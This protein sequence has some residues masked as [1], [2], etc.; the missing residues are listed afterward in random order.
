MTA[1]ADAVKDSFNALS[2]PE[3]RDVAEHAVQSLPSASGP[4]V[5]VLWLI[6][7]S[8]FALLLVGGATAVVYMTVNAKDPKDLLPLVTAA[9][10]VLAGLLAPSPARQSIR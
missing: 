6:I 7:V 8:S 4:I 5:N 10:G 9:L 1:A 2:V 3:K